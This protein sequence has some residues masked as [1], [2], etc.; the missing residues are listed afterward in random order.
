[1]HRLMRCHLQYYRYMQ[2]V[3][4]AVPLVEGVTCGDVYRN[5]EEAIAH[6]VAAIHGALLALKLLA[7][8]LSAGVQSRGRS[9]DSSVRL[10]CAVGR[11]ARA[12]TAPG[13][14]QGSNLAT[15]V[16]AHL[17]ALGDPADAKGASHVV[18]CCATT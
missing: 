10:L 4:D 6:C 15:M 12:E 2:R 5:I 18:I 3:R 14:S 1:M 17:Y 11:S 7:L 8:A 13:F 16:A 9:T